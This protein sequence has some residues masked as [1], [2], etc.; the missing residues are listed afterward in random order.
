MYEFIDSNLMNLI[1]G[2]AGTIHPLLGSFTG[3]A[4]SIAAI[5]TLIYFGSEAYKIM[6]GEKTFE[7]IPL[8]RPFG[9]LLLIMFWGS[10]LS[11]L[12]AP[13]NQIH[14]AGKQMFV[15]KM[16]TVNN[17]NK[18]RTALQDSIMDNITRKREEIREAQ[19]RDDMNFF[20]RVGADLSAV[21]DKIQGLGMWFVG[22]IRQGL[23][24]IVESFTQILWQAMVYLMLFLRLIFKGVLG[25]I[26]PLSLALSILPMFKGTFSRWV[27]KY[28]TVSLYGCITYI[29]L[30]LSTAIIQYA[31]ETDVQVL[32]QAN[33]DDT[34]LAMQTVFNTGFVNGFL[35]AIL[36]S[37]FAL[38]QVPKLA[39]WIVE[40]GAPAAVGGFQHRA[41]QAQKEA[42]RV[43][44]SVVT[45]FAAGSAG[46]KGG[47][48]YA[49]G[50]GGYAGGGGGYAGG[51]GGY[52]GGGGGY[53]G[54]GGGYAG[55]GGGYAG[56][57][58]G[59]R[60]SGSGSGNSS[61]HSS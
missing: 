50:G 32:R 33:V 53:A 13:L 6:A 38:L 43:A 23:F 27:S 57:G 3:V 24:N 40:S 15:N 55:G 30:T 37:I 8:L 60:N 17:L 35:P 2:I 10:F 42:G 20:E 12:D 36:M 18:T 14:Y 54:G 4:R 44:A 48:G 29:M 1:D 45:G 25:I 41:T 28:I 11:G 19:N 49:G 21:R 34:A 59:G 7:I 16:T 47:G 61:G 51:G 9:I 31:I 52:A 46:A 26:G 58:G 56:G 39:D 5:L 22:W